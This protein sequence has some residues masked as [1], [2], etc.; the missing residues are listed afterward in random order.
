MDVNASR[1]TSV[2]ELHTLQAILQER[3]HRKAVQRSV[4][5][6]AQLVPSC[7]VSLLKIGPHGA[8]RFEA[9]ANV[10]TSVVRG[11]ERSFSRDGLPRN[12]MDVVRT[13]KPLVIEDLSSY[14]DWREPAP[15]TASVSDPSAEDLV[16][17]ADDRL[18]QSKRFGGG[19]ITSH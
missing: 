19:H 17:L 7:S 1:D 4:E 11:A 5:V 2:I 10:P 15:P 3:S 9:W 18:Y 12:L 6:I 14:A 13:R 16:K 8:L